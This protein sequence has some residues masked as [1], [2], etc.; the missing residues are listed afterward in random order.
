MLTNYNSFVIFILIFLISI[1]ISFLV[2]SLCEFKTFRKINK[3]SEPLTKDTIEDKNISLEEFKDY[4]PESKIDII[5]VKNNIITELDGT[6]EIF[7]PKE[8]I[9]KDIFISDNVKL[10]MLE[11]GKPEIFNNK[12]K[13]E[14][15]YYGN[16]YDIYCKQIK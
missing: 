5:T 1:V 11:P 12:I 3:Y 15:F 2:I 8:D 6:Y 10:M 16:I 7:T 13:I 9:K 14:A 4:T